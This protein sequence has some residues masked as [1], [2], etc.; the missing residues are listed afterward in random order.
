MTEILGAPAGVGDDPDVPE[1]AD[2]EATA[3]EVELGNTLG[4]SI[5]PDDDY[6]NGGVK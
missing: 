3:D 4:A 1:V 5:D 6:D 2:L